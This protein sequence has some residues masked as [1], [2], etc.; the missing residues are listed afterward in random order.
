M[1][2]EGEDG[3]VLIFQNNRRFGFKLLVEIELQRYVS[4]KFL[5]NGL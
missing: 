3:K 2:R 4:S 1:I 5:K